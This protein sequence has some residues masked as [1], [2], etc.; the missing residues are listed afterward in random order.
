MTSDRLLSPPP[1]FDTGEDEGGVLNAQPIQG[2]LL[3]GA[4]R[5]RARE[6]RVNQTNT[7]KLLW[8]KLRREYIKAR[9]RRQH[10]SMALLSI[11]AV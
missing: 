2:G 3:E 11:F 5:Q 7:E 4:T 10:R 8:S 9:F 1:L 6:M